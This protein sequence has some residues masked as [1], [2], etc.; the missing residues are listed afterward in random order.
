[1]DFFSVPSL[2]R[3]LWTLERFK[4]RRHA[5][6]YR[7]RHAETLAILSRASS[8]RLESVWQETV[9]CGDNI[10]NDL[11]PWLPVQVT[12]IEETSKRMQS[13]WE[14]FYGGK[15]D[16]PEMQQ[17]IANTVSLLESLNKR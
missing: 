10:R 6:L 17:R 3:L 12:S 11:L 7:L 13:M 16:S 2:R 8:D 1:M 14:E 9:A 5:E 15:M 4:R